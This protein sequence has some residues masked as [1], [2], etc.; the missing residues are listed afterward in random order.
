MQQN[1]TSSMIKNIVYHHKQE[2]L[3]VTFHKGQTYAYFGIPPE[4]YY[5]LTHAPSK[6]EY[7]H[8]YVI[9]SYDV[10]PVSLVN[11]H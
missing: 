10:V 5:E 4:V 11:G 8:E 1:I 3:E 9:G 7:M 2:I 6:G